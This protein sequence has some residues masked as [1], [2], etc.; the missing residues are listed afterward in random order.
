[1]PRADGSPSWPTDEPPRNDTRINTGLVTHASLGEIPVVF[2]TRPY[3][4]GGRAVAAFPLL[5]GSAVAANC[6]R[7]TWVVAI[8]AYSPISHRSRMTDVIPPRAVPS[9]GVGTVTMRPRGFAT[10]Y[11][12]R[13]P[14]SSPVWPNWAEARGARRG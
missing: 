7:P 1:M 12:T 8:N 5:A 4:G 3:P 14:Q 10:G 6:I 9:T 2:P 11:V 13:W